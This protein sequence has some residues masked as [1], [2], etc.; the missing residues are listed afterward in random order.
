MT[1]NE[2][3]A[4]AEDEQLQR[5][6]DTD[7][8]T[9]D[10]RWG[11]SYCVHNH[12]IGTPGGADF[13]CGLCEDGLTYFVSDPAYRLVITV[14]DSSFPSDSKV[15]RSDLT[16]PPRY[17]LKAL[18][19]LRREMRSV[20]VIA[21]DTVIPVTFRMEEADGGRWE[22][23]MVNVKTNVM[24]STRATDWTDIGQAVADQ[25]GVP[26]GSVYLGEWGEE[27]ERRS[28]YVY[29]DVEAQIDRR[30]LTEEQLRRVAAFE[31]TK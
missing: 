16:D 14:A 5:L 12:Y 3:I 20:S 21:T 6:E 22:D 25:L 24:V 23:P 11:G 9:D 30:D 10:G 15:W 7:P 17:A 28:G 19:R 27:V 13:M 31:V 18:A 2:Q 8:S 29:T 1:L 26:D 4:L